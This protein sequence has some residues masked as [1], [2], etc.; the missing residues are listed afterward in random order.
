MK[1]ETTTQTSRSL[2]SYIAGFLLS[3]ILTLVAYG[4]VQSHISNNHTVFSHSFLI[5]IIFVLAI[6]QLVVQLVFFLHLGRKGQGWNLGLLGF[7]AVVVL[8]LV[9]GSLW[10]MSN[11]NYHMKYTPKELHQYL[12]NQDSL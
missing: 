6:M 9:I 10:I 1:P 3:I 8:I 2:H 12:K 4:F 5:G 11:L 7:A